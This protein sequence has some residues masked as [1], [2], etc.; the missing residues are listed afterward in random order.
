MDSSGAIFCSICEQEVDMRRALRIPHACGCYSHTGCHAADSDFQC[1]RC[2]VSSKAASYKKPYEEVNNY[3]DFDWV[4]V[5]RKDLTA[6]VTSARVLLG[7]WLAIGATHIQDTENPLILMKAKMDLELIMRRRKWC[8]GDFYFRGV[9]LDNFLTHGY[10]LSD[11]QRVSKDVRE[12]P[13]ATLRRFGLTPDH[14]VEFNHLLPIQQLQFKPQDIASR[15]TGGGL[16][17]NPKAKAV[18]SGASGAVWNMEELIYLGFVFDDLVAIGVNTKERWDSLGKISKEDLKKLGARRQDILALAHEFPSSS[19]DEQQHE[20]EEE[21][22]LEE[23]EI[24]V[25]D[26]TRVQKAANALYL[27]PRRRFVKE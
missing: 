12:R 24:P 23:V 14:L 1:A 25:M 8:L 7:K 17:Y 6:R 18:C 21:I 13:L 20:E 11:L 5:D 26:A 10:Q 3:P 16:G 2:N 9:T 22:E 15:L 4:T 19:E 27:Q